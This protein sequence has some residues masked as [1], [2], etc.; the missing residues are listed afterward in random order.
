MLILTK[1]NNNIIIQSASGDSYTILIPEDYIFN[2]KVK[3]KSLVTSPDG[4]EDISSD[5]LERIDKNVSQLNKNFKKYYNINAFNTSS[6]ASQEASMN[7][8][9]EAS[10]NALYNEVSQINTNLHGLGFAMLI[11]I[12]F[13]VVFK[14]IRGWR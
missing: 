7:A 1:G 2:V 12:M 6:D 11:F 14:E 13:Y 10:M 3:N 9:Q 4:I 5:A 8:S